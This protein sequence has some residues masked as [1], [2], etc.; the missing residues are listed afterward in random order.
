VQPKIFSRPRRHAPF[1]ADSLHMF[2]QKKPN[3]K[4]DLYNPPY[5]G[6]RRARAAQK[7]CILH[8]FLIS[9]CSRG[10]IFATRRTRARGARVRRRRCALL[11]V[12]MREAAWMECSRL[13]KRLCSHWHLVCLLAHPTYCAVSVH[14]DVS[15][16]LRSTCL[17][18]TLSSDHGP[19]MRSLPGMATHAAEV[20]AAAVFLCLPLL[21]GVLLHD[22]GANAIALALQ[23]QCAFRWLRRCNARSRAPAA[24]CAWIA[25]AP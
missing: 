6:T 24:A 23:W 15:T 17:T 2:T 4:H 13:Y 18:Q 20:A 1:T 7:V 8:P 21:C 11:L 14:R 16:M 3:A 5:E 12:S 10:M 22:T 25:S 19:F 9:R